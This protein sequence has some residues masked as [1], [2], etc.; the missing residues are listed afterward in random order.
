MSAEDD[1]SLTSA[2]WPEIVRKIRARTPARLL[3]GRAGASYRTRT[4][5]DLR[6]AHATARDA[7]RNELSLKDALGAE[8]VQRWNLF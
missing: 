8:F 7:V 4:Q 5:L 2:G 1:C 6:A 3:V